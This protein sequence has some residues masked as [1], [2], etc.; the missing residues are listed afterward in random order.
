MHV[1]IYLERGGAGVVKVEFALAL[2]AQ[3]YHGYRAGWY[4]T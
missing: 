4:R 2:L 3:A 1:Y